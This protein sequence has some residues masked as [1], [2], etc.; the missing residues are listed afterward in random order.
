VLPGTGG[1]RV[2]LPLT[3]SHGSGDHGGGRPLAAARGCRLLRLFFFLLKTR[4]VI[5]AGPRQGQASLR[6]VRQRTLDMACSARIGAAQEGGRKRKNAAAT[7]RF[8][9][10][11][12]YSMFYSPPPRQELAVRGEHRHPQVHRCS[13][14]PSEKPFG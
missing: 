14:Q 4:N 8:R 5:L 13:T 1:G 7:G 3:A 10:Q 12:P 6:S 11:G 9:G 2:L